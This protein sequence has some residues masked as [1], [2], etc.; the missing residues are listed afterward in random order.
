MGMVR[1][2]LGIG[3]RLVLLFDPALLHFTNSRHIAPTVAGHEHGWIFHRR[4]TEELSHTGLLSTLI[5]LLLISIPA[6][7][8]G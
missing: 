1:S 7:V 5:K 8:E 2:E 6:K 4:R 3:F